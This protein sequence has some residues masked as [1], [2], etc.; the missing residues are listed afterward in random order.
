MDGCVSWASWSEVYNKNWMALKW[1][2]IEQEDFDFKTEFIWTGH[3]SSVPFWHSVTE[4][5]WFGSKT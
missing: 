4:Q 1:S 5:E 3:L 2:S